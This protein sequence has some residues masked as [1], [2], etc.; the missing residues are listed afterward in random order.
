MFENGY[1]VENILKKER[2]SC[3]ININNICSN[4]YFNPNKIFKTFKSSHF[5]M[6]L[7]VVTTK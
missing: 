2:F 1:I 3:A 7:D 4:C 5:Q 6:N